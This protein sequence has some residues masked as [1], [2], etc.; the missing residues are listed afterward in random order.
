MVYKAQVSSVL[1][2]VAERKHAVDRNDGL[3]NARDR[4]KEAQAGN[5]GITGEF[6]VV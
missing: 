1:A 2:P 5:R 3:T 6:P 4:V